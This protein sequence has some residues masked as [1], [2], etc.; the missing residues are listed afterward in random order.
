MVYM[1][2]RQ[3]GIEE[4]RRAAE[5]NAQ[6][7]AQAEIKALKEEVAAL[8]AELALARSVHQ[9]TWFRWFKSSPIM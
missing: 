7:E 5:H 6:I 3:A 2:G 9:R 8:R 1:R 4:T